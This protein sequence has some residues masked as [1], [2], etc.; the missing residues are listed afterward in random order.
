M[1]GRRDLQQRQQVAGHVRYNEH[2]YLPVTAPVKGIVR[3]VHVVVGQTVR[4]GDA[5]AVISSA[6]IGA[7]R[8]DVQ[9]HEADLQLAERAFAS[10]DEMTQ[11]VELLLE[12]LDQRP[13]V[14]VVEQASRDKLLGEHRAALI[15]AYSRLRRAETELDRASPLGQQGVVSGRVLQERQAEREAAAAQ[16]ASICETTRLQCRQ[17]RDRARV[18]VEDA[19]RRLAVSR[20]HL[21]ALAGTDG[22]PATPSPGEN[23]NDVVL[24]APIRGEVTQRLVRPATRVEASDLLFVIANTELLWVTAEV[25]ENDWQAVS[26]AVGKEVRIEAPAVPDLQATARIC[27]VG[28]SVSEDTL[29]LPMTAELPNPDHRLKPG[30]FVWVSIPVRDAPGVLAVPA[31]ALAHHN[32]A[33]FVFVCQAPGIYRRQDV[34][35]GLET[36]EWVEIREGLQDGE[37][38]VDEGVFA[39]KSELLLEKEAS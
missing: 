34:V 15:T 1:V 27:F 18:A 23:L 13:E 36:P 29:T 10:L 32:G 39:L 28:S 38:I 24:Y 17:Q 8:S 22:L 20:E 2:E 35:V 21:A 5:L 25:R 3:T 33:T 7:A 14:R 16:F 30:F 26:G 6:E 37:T 12:Q 4:A 9:L 19:R 11:N 31:G